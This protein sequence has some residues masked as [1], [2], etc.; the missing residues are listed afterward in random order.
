M[1]RTKVTSEASRTKS[2]RDAL[3][4][5]GSAVG[6][7]VEKD[8]ALLPPPGGGDPSHSASDTLRCRLSR[9]CSEQLGRASRATSAV[10]AVIFHERIH[11]GVCGRPPALGCLRAVV[12]CAACHWACT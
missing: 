3:P 12:G 1:A 7:G 5:W 9:G 11:T 4:H 6:A 10:I 2:P 8:A